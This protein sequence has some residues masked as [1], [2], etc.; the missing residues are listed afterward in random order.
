MIYEYIVVVSHSL[1][2]T[3]PISLQSVL[4]QDDV[5]SWNA[6]CRT[7]TLMVSTVV[8]NSLPDLLPSHSYSASHSNLT[9]L[10][11][12]P[13]QAKSTDVSRHLHGLFPLEESR[14]PG[15]LRSPFT[16]SQV[17]TQI[18]LLA[19]V[20]TESTTPKYP[21]LLP[22]LLYLLIIIQHTFC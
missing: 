14:R 3:S 7:V 4:G 19:S 2:T 21:I 9:S 1:L 20:M 6:F 17:L 18:H 10:W 13:E 15:L 16:P 12:L 22:C 11:V 5:L 8:Q